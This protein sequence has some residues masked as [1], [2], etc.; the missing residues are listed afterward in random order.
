VEHA[1][2]GFP[3]GT[4]LGLYLSRRL[5]EAM[6]GW[7]RLER[8]SPGEGSRFVLELPLVSEAPV[9][10]AAVTAEPRLEGASAPAAARPATVPAAATRVTSWLNRSGPTP[11]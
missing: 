4:G 10:Q 2:L 9:P 8:S 6:G 5:A 3:A 1:E 7:L 11:R